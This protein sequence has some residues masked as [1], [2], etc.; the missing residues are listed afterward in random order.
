MSPEIFTCAP[1]PAAV[2]EGA[3]AHW[4]RRRRRSWRLLYRIMIGGYP[5]WV[6]G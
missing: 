5:L 4:R 2:A 3:M 6:I 1:P